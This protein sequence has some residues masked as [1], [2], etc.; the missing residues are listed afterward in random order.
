MSA[1]GLAA[2]HLALI[3]DL[4]AAAVEHRVLADRAGELV[5][6][7]PENAFSHSRDTLVVVEELFAH[8]TRSVL[9][10]TFVIQQPERVLAPLMRRMEEVPGLAVSIFVHVGRGE[11]DTRTD[12][13]VLADF[14]GVLAKAWGSLR[15]PKVYYDPRGLS[16]DRTTRASWHA[17]C[18]IADDETSLV[19]SANFTEWAQLRNVE[20]GVLIR[21]R[22]FSEQLRSHFDGLASSK[23]VERLPG[24]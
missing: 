18:L 1:E 13:S 11:H 7:G 23:Q 12:T 17:K 4:T 2:P 10:S 3:V 15:R 9:L 20:A 5:W 21:S 22:E 8:A 24:F 14:S 16:T 6:T 19:T